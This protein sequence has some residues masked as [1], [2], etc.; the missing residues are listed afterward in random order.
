M[1]HVR[2]SV[3]V[4]SAFFFLLLLAPA[5][6]SCGIKVLRNVLSTSH[7]APYSVARSKNAL[8]HVEVQDVT[9]CLRY[10]Q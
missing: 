6:P 8:P 2:S 3:V 10:R 9:V 1:L 4:A 5:P 7:P